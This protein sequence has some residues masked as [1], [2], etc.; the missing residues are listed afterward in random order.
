MLETI[1]IFLNLPK[2]ELPGYDISWRMFC[3][4]LRRKY[5]LMLLDRMSYKHQLSLPSLLC[6]ACQVALVVKTP[7]ANAGDVRDIG[8]TIGLRR[9]PESA[10]QPTQVFL[11]G[12]F[13]DRGAWQATVHRATQSTTQSRRWLK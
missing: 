9:S 11:A 8:L 4:H 6:G 2:L 12:E 13:H 1:S 5:I 10:W 3:V 7:P